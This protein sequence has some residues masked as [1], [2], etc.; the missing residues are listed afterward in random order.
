V[1]KWIKKYQG[2]RLLDK[3]RVK[4]YKLPGS[5]TIQYRL[6][7]RHKRKSWSEAKWL[8]CVPQLQVFDAIREC[9]LLVNH[10]K[11]NH[12]LLK[13][14]EKYYNIS[15]KQVNAFVATCETCNHKNPVLK[16]FKG[17]KKPILSE[18]FRD[19]FQVDLIDMRAREAPDV[20]GN[21]MKWILTLK[22]HF[23]QLTYLA[24]LPRKKAEYVAYELDRIF[25][26]IG[27]PAIF[28]TDNGTEFTANEILTLLKRY[29]RAIITVTG[30]PRTPRDQGSVESVNK[31][32]K[33]VI[34]QIQNHERLNGNAVPNW[35]MLLGACMQTI[36][37]K[38]GK[39]KFD[40]SPYMAVFGQPYNQPIE[41]ELEVMRK[42]KTIEERLDVSNDERLH[43][44]ADEVCLLGESNHL[45]L[46]EQPYWEDDDKEN[47]SAVENSQENEQENSL[48]PKYDSDRQMYKNIENSILADIQAEMFDTEESLSRK[49]ENTRN[50]HQHG[51]FDWIQRL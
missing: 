50:I 46:P 11:M 39:Q 44:L 2:E 26:L 36:N 16:Q 30:R 1:K 47:I 22:D 43:Q 18:N 17:A 4:E 28:H 21:S 38:Q 8:I 24:P 10:M 51:L 41:C 14:H 25:G 49:D 40:V 20:Y 9:H 34:E 23:T 37:S 42:C 12:T 33:N 48:T 7:R 3:Y 15:E 27:Y 32:V 31:L 29:N 5:D 6:L 19:R 35:P 13:V 45:A